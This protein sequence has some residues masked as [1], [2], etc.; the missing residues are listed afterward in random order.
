MA[1][2]W[3]R[4]GNKLITLTFNVLNNTTFSDIYSCYLLFRRDLLDGVELRVDGWAQ[5]AE[6]LGMIV[7]RAKRMYEVPISYFGRTYEEGKMIRWY[8][9]AG[10]LGTIASTR[11]LGPRRL[12]SV[13]G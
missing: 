5:Q 1:Y 6:I 8:H 13:G 2:Y 3:H 10:V 4:V 12:R 9:T 11:L 7:H